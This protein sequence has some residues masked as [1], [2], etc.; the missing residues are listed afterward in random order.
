VSRPVEVTV[1]LG[2]E[3]VEVIARR[4]AEIVRADPPGPPPR[5]PYLSPVEAAEVLRCRKRRVYELVADGRLARHG[6][7]RRLL[8]SRREVEKLAAGR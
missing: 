7:G 6:E 8:V 2:P 3:Q 4:V 5:S 1:T